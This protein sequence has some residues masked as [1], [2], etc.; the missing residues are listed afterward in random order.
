MIDIVV[1][2]NSIINACSKLNIYMIN[3]NNQLKV[4]SSN[5]P[6]GVKTYSHQLTLQ[7]P[8]TTSF[9]VPQIAEGSFKYSVIRIGEE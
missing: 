7:H 3:D 5:N 6:V 8:S 9:H 4:Q 1:K 2:L